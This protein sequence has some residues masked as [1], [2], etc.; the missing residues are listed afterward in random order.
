[1]ILAVSYQ[2]ARYLTG[3]AI[4]KRIKTSQ[5]FTS[6]VDVVCMLFGP[7]GFEE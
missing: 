4:L 2:T 6:V 3:S 5:A 1:M 7:Y